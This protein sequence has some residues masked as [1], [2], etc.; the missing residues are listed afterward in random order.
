MSQITSTPGALYATFDPIYSLEINSQLALTASGI[1]GSLKE[2]W[3]LSQCCLIVYCVV[4]T[5]ALHLKC[6]YGQE[7]G[8]LN[9]CHFNLW[10]LIIYLVKDNPCYASRMGKRFMGL[11]FIEVPCINVEFE[12]IHDY[13]VIQ[14]TGQ[15]Q[16]LLQI[17]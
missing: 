11:H 17:S 3:K 14:L 9:L 4:T 16:C 7:S 8:Q 12:L 5:K 10:V 15:K 6:H 1:I 13:S 2:E